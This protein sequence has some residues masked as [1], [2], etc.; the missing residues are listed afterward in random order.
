MQ[1]L[2]VELRDDQLVMRGAASVG[3]I[4]APVQLV[5]SASVENTRLRVHLHEADVN[6]V[7]VPEVVRGQLEQQLQDQL[8]QSLGTYHV[9]VRSVRMGGGE[10][11]V[12]GTRQ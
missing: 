9:E 2:T 5:A 11:V 10:L 6:G 3:W 8:D 1:D 4:Q 12:S 7:Q